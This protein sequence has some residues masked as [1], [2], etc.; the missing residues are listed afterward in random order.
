M[1]QAGT[2]LAGEQ[3]CGEGLGDVG[4]H[5]SWTRMSQQ[6]ALAA[7]AA[8]SVLCSVNKSTV[9]WQRGVISPLYSKLRP[10]LDTMSARKTLTLFSYTKF[11]LAHPSCL[12]RSHWVAAL[13]LTVLSSFPNSMSS[14]NFMTM[15][16]HYLL[17]VTDK[18]VEQD[19]SQYR[20]L[21]TLD[22]LRIE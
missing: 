22:D 6:H 13:P 5:V 1:I 7:R 12:S 10:R 19:W 2:W 8:N 16:S 4:R 20:S 3:L 9:C 14:V 21:Q 15:H 17:Q 18:V 11:P